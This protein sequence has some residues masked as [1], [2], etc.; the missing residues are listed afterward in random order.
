MISTGDGKED[1]VVVDPKSGGLF[2]YMNNG[3]QPDG[4]WG[5]A[6]YGPIATCI[7]GPGSGVRLADMDGK[8]LLS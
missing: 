2:L 8:P 5:W 1:F 4:S 3:Q 7:G 6:P